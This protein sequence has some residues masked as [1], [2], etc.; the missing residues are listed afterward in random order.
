ML[1]LGLVAWYKTL[2][3]NKGIT[4][5]FP[6]IDL[7]KEQVSIFSDLWREEFAGS[8]LSSCIKFD[9]S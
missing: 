6:D 9:Q 5:C 8:E 1:D 7:G 3:L 2:V 4:P